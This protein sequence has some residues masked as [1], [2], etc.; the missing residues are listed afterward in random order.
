MVLDDAAALESALGA[1][2]AEAEVGRAEDDRAFLLVIRDDR[3]LY[4]EG[5]LD[6][7]GLTGATRFV[8][9]LLG[10]GAM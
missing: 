3:V 6:D 10:G 4:S 9:A 7:D 5:E 1:A 8:S 2:G